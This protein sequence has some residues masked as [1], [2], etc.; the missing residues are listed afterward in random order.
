MKRIAV[1]VLSVALC[2]APRLEAQQHFPPR[3][4]EKSATAARILGIVPG[5]GHMY[6]GEP[7]HGFAYMGGVALIGT[8]ALGEAIASCLDDTQSSGGCGSNRAS[9]VLTVAMFG[10]WGWSIYDAGSAAHR[11]NAKRLQRMSLVIAPGS[12]A[13]RETGSSRTARLGLRLGL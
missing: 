4:P 12:T 1:L 6:A 11:T 13:V 2:H 5:V 7:G 9:D 10:L 3:T 8:V